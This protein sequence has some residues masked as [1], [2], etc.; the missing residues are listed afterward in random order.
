[1]PKLPD[2]SNLS[3]VNIGAPRSMVDMPV[4]DIAGAAGAVARGISDAGQA[5]TSFAVERQERFRKQERFDTKMGLLKAEEAYAER[6]KDLDPLDP[7]YVEKK[8]AFRREVFA[9]VLS[10]VK[11]PENRQFFDLSTYEDFVNVGLRAEGEHKAARGEK[12]KTDVLTFYGDLEKRV[13]S[14][15]FKG[16]PADELRS[17]LQDTTDL[18]QNQILEL[19]RQLVPKIGLASVQR[20]AKGLYDTGVALTPE[21]RAAV[22]AVAS[23]PGMPDWMGGYL[24][25]TATLESSGGRRT[26]NPN[27]PGVLGVFQF[28]ERTARDVGLRPEDRG[29]VA[30]STAGAARLAIS[31]FNELKAAL[32][33]DP[34]MS[35]LYLAH[36]Q[37]AAGAIKLL[38]NPDAPAASIVGEDAVVQNGGWETMTAEQ[39]S[40]LWDIKYDGSD[41]PDDPDEVRE[42]LATDPAFASLS[43]DEIDEAVRY[44][45][46]LD[47]AREREQREQTRIQ[48]EEIYREFSDLEASGG[49][50]Q[51]W[52]DAQKEAG[53]ASARE[54]RIFENTLRNSKK[55]VTD[56]AEAVAGIVRQVNGAK[57]DDDVTAAQIALD[58][59][60]SEG[61]VSTATKT[62]IAAGVK[63]RRNAVKQQNEFVTRGERI[64]ARAVRSRDYSSGDVAED[65]IT[66]MA[67]K[68]AFQNWLDKN[69]NASELDIVTQAGKIAK[70]AAIDRVETVRSSIDLPLGM[71]GV[72][73]KAITREDIY[74]YAAGLQKQQPIP[75]READYLR[76]VEL[77]K[78]WLEIIDIQEMAGE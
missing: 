37:G 56:D 50:T 43:Q 35:E 9:P 49:L 48:R 46:E 64:I 68:I 60:F 71:T 21:V 12:A 54:I 76:E 34:S 31:R 7:E 10:A 52:I 61:K 32:G 26:V 19:E 75:G 53:V 29:D 33:R 5:V 73:R 24:A 63:A 62:R 8:K 67:G 1:M 25:R 51:D 69:P 22:D 59:A 40:S 28:D 47:R 23:T 18:N 15:S 70:Q 74:K 57:S 38:Q 3:G 20:T 77:L 14:G 30:L 44:T 27:N 58:E 6:V 17:F 41:M 72:S 36:Q 78:K 55:N 42:L 13:A 2:A 45:V 66:E 65:E 39:F 11:D 16:N 4:P